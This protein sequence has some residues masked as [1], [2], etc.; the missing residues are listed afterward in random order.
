MGLVNDDCFVVERRRRRKKRLQIR[1]W[2]K[3]DYS[4]GS[5]A[6][7]PGHGEPLLTGQKLWCRDVDIPVLHQRLHNQFP[8]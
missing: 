5:L 8:L 4:R 1:K 7:L 3:I 2:K 6:S